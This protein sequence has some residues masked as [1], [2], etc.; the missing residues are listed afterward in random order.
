MTMSLLEYEAKEIKMDLSGI[1]LKLSSL[2]M[3]NFSKIKIF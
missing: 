1:S 2:K 3:L